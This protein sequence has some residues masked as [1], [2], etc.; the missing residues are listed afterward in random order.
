MEGYDWALKK[1]EA[2]L[3]CPPKTDHLI[4]LGSVFGGQANQPKINTI[5]SSTND[6]HW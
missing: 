5:G 4:L 2:F 3:T 6:Y 1:I